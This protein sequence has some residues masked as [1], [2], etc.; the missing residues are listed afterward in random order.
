MVSSRPHDVELPSVWCSPP[1]LP[2][3][4]GVPVIHQFLFLRNTPPAPCPQQQPGVTACDLLHKHA[5]RACVPTVYCLPACLV[6]Q[7]FYNRAS[8]CWLGGNPADHSDCSNLEVKMFFP[9]YSQLSLWLFP[10]NEI[11]L[12]MLNPWSEAGSFFFLFPP[13]CC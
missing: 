12:P 10:G 1:S 9:W 4:T 3:A 5:V 13:L 11:C 7:C 6:P 8:I 2:Q